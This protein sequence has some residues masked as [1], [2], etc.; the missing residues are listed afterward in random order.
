MKK[1][2]ICP[3]NDVMVMHYTADFYVLTIRSHQVN[4]NE[5]PCQSKDELN[6]TFINKNAALE[7]YFRELDIQEQYCKSLEALG[8]DCMYWCDVELTAFDYE[9]DYEDGEHIEDIG[10]YP[11]GAVSFHVDVEGE[12]PF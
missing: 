8:N 11:V 9:D 12:L 10:E 1:E 4:Y 6:L 2:T 7:S 3:L 5:E